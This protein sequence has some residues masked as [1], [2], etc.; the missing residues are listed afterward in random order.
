ML[1]FGFRCNTLGAAA[2]YLG[3]LNI[4]DTAK[5]AG[6][7]PQAPSTDGAAATAEDEAVEANADFRDLT[8][9]ELVAGAGIVP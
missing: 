7:H 2:R 9:E 6:D 3:K 5:Y 8:F 4:T 1:H